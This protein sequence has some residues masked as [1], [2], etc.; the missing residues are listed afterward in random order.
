MI[1]RY[2]IQNS[3]Q[4]VLNSFKINA[5]SG[6]VGCLQSRIR[7]EEEEERRERE[8]KEASS[9]FKTVGQ[10]ERERKKERIKRHF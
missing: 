2:Q 10:R 4:I 8:A 7:E 1:S 3:Q 5:Q 6:S 9:R